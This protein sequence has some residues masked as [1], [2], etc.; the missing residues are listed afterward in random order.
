[1][2]RRVIAKR[3]DRYRTCV[4]LIDLRLAAGRFSED[5]EPEFDSWVQIKASRPLQRGMFVA[6]VAGRSMEPLI[7]DRAFC[8]FQRKA[9][10]VR[11]GMI[12]DVQLHGFEDPEHGGRHTVKKLAVTTERDPSTGEI[13]RRTTLVPLNPDFTPMQV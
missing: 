1:V 5:Q 11:D 7:P 2:L 10:I 9:P 13:R 12:G 4:P 6:Q 8:L 3:D